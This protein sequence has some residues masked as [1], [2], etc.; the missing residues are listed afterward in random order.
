MNILK[1]GSDDDAHEFVVELEIDDARGGALCELWESAPDKGEYGGPYAIVR[2]TGGKL[3]PSVLRASLQRFNE[4]PDNRW[5]WTTEAL[6]AY[7]LHDLCGIALL[8]CR[9]PPSSGAAE[10]ASPPGGRKR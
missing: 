6:A 8:D 2:C 9:L 5:R 3:V 10:T 1:D 4:P 7:L